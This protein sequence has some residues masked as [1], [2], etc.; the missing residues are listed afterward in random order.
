MTAGSGDKSVVKDYWLHFVSSSQPY[1][2]E[3][4][5]ET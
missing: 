1:N 5:T 2:E 3:L 4:L